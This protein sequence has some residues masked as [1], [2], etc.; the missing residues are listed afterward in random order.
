MPTSLQGIAQKAKSPTQYRVRNLYGMRNADLVRDGWRAIQKNAA[1][2]VDRVSAPEDAHNLEDNIKHLVARLKSNSYR[3]KLVRRHDIPQGG[4]AVRPLGI[5]VVED[6]LVQLAVTRR[7]TAIYAQD[8]LRCRDGSRPHVGALDA[9]DALTI[10]LP[11]GRYNWVVEADITG[12]FEHIDHEWILRMLAERIDD[13]ALIR[14]IKT[15]LKAGVLDTDGTV[16]HPAT[17]SPQGGVVSPILAKL[18]LH[19]ALDRWLEKVVKRH[20]HGEA[21]LLR[22]ADD[23]V[24]AFEQREAAERCYTVLG[25]RLRKFGLELS[26]D[27]TRLL[28]FSRRPAAAPTRFEC[29]GLEFHWGKDRAGQAHL[30]RRT[31]RQ[32]VRH[33]LKRFTA[34]CNEHRH[35]R[36]RVLFERLNIKLRGYDNYDGVHGNTASLQQFFN[37]AIR[38][39]MKWLN[40]RSQRRGYT[41]HGYTAVLQ[42]FKVERPRIVGRP[43]P[44]KAVLMA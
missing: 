28:P 11:F 3:A 33:S 25:H 2:G 16:R 39:L 31:S 5:P 35:L 22:D 24:C 34:W 42:P 7:L 20:C 41:W 1:Y 6:K 8:F 9:V 32:K 19:S 21:C 38:I 4:G 44:K 26:G 12:F 14:L 18:Y 29:L 15:W 36:L 40:R 37:S 13:R 23:Y 27:K 10:T 17:G 43:R 30:K